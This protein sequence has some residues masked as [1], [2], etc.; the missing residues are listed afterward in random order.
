MPGELTPL[1]TLHIV[2]AWA[3]LNLSPQLELAFLDSG[4]TPQ[5]GAFEANF[6]ERQ[7]YLFSFWCPNPSGVPEAR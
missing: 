1:A 4:Q 5:F 3:I 6:I 2:S 7:T